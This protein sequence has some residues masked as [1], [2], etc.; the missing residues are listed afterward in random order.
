MQARAAAERPARCVAIGAALLAVL[1]CVVALP[2]AQTLWGEQAA[3]TSSSYGYA[4]VGA[5]AGVLAWWHARAR[6]R[7]GTW[8]VIFASATLLSSATS[9]LCLVSLTPDG[10]A[11]PPAPGLFQQDVSGLCLVSVS[12]RSL[13]VSSIP[14]LSI[15]EGAACAGA[16]CELVG[17]ARDT[18]PSEDEADGRRLLA[19]CPCLVLVGFTR[20]AAWRP[21]L[22][23]NGPWHEP[24]AWLPEGPSALMVLPVA[25]TIALPLLL[26]RARR[27]SGTDL[28]APPLPSFGPCTV[29][30]LCMGELGWRALSRVFPSLYSPTLPLSLLALAL[31]LSALALIALGK[32][33]PAPSSRR[34]KGARGDAAP[35]LGE[36]MTREA[37]RLGVS[38][39]DVD[40]FAAALEQGQLTDREREAICGKVLGSSSRLLGERMGI[41]P[42]TVREYQRRA[43]E[44]L[45]DDLVRF[46]SLLRGAREEGARAVGQDDG[47]ASADQTAGP[48]PGRG[49]HIALCAL[50]TLLLVP[51]G[52]TE[53]LG[54]PFS[55]VPLGICAGLLLAWCATWA[56][57][58][59]AGA[60]GAIAAPLLPSLVRASALCAGGSTLLAWRL[61]SLGLD[62]PAPRAPALFL[63]SATYVAA[64]ATSARHAP[65]RKPARTEGGTFSASPTTRAL[66][67][68]GAGLVV[69][70]CWRSVEHLSFNAECLLLLLAMAVAG[71]WASHRIG[72]P[73]WETGTWILAAALLWPARRLFSLSAAA[74]LA[75]VPL[76]A[77]CVGARAAA[78]G[79]GREGRALGPWGT[80][81]SE[82]ALPLFALGACGGLILVNVHGS[83]LA[84]AELAAIGTA[85]PEALEGAAL[86]L[87][88]LLAAAFAA[89]LARDVD[90]H[91]CRELVRQTAWVPERVL[92]NLVARG[93]SPEQARIMERLAAGGSVAQT[94]REL[95]YSTSAVAA[96][97]TECYRR[98]GIRTRAQ[99]TAL[100]SD[101]PRP[102]NA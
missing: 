72:R 48:G 45:G 32:A 36:E 80:P 1:A 68:L 17:R 14:L 81:P 64:L 61:A 15:V 11:T 51:V 37:L 65:S 31:Q 38:E 94:A 82:D 77:S 35:A 49:P 67:A 18:A 22:P 12:L 78:S 53:L 84:Y 4:A 93:V 99:L 30:A 88:G 3:S 87:A 16:W 39:K 28:D 33:L 58:H 66:G 55:H 60:R 75:C 46:E 42:S 40:A 91:E 6:L 26:L 5:L 71:A 20:A 7:A 73:S 57:A 69:E 76:L 56:R 29:G 2:L 19:L 54:T 27:R 50:T 8:T 10:S 52:S 90:A 9:L 24:G 92:A 25:E 100:V 23:C 21:L 97:R 86:L 98:L 63:A 41:A 95:H 83:A 59:G 74:V 43:R 85:A 70:E 102:R 44:K 96:V 62:V 101:P 89:S 34:A 79:G 13:L 47:L